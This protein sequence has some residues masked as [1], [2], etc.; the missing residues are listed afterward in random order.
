[1]SKDIQ[2]QFN[3]TGYAIEKGVFTGAEI[4]TLENE[5]DQIV[6]Q[7]KKSGENINARWG[8]DLTRHIEDSDSEVI[9]THNIQSYSSIMLHMVQNETL[10]D[11]AESLIGPDIILHHTK[12]FCKPPKKGSA[13]P[14]HQDWSYF[15]TQKNSMIAAVVHLS[16]STENMGC[17][18]VVPESHKLGKIENS[19]GHSHVPGIHD[20]SSLETALPIEAKKG[21]VLFFHC[22]TIHGSTPNISDHSRKTI[23]IQ[24]YSGKDTI[25]DENMHTN[26]QLVLRGWNYQATR[27]NIGNIKS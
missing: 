18:R 27:E 17:F 8:S 22:C 13:F 23:L 12:L 24:L 19:N 3:K 4:K 26:V 14:L 21:D 16:E 9:H 1:M 25:V 6:T 20:H 5:F 2:S 10:L 15:P 11:L 7:L